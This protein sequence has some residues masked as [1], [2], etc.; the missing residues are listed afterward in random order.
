M[1]VDQFLP[2]E[3]KSL[4]TQR[5]ILDA[6]EEMLARYDFKYLTVRNICQTAGTASG[7]FYHHFGTKENVLIHCGKRLFHRNL[8][9]NPCP[10]EI[11]QGDYLHQ[12]MWYGIVLACFCETLGKEYVR[13]IY[14]SGENASDLFAELYD[15]YLFPVLDYAMANGYIQCHFKMPMDDEKVLKNLKKDI[16]IVTRGTVLYWCCS[17]DEELVEPF[18][19]TMEHML[20]RIVTGTRT[21][22][23]P[24]NY[25]GRTMLADAGYI[26]RLH[27]MDFAEYVRCKENGEE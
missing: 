16:L 24:A 26:D 20:Y 18:Y 5:K 22:K 3:L 8:R 19:A 15:R 23:R 7:S 17:K 21:E 9:N 6:S 14:L 11:D 13:T 27:M 1:A 10:P 12:A 25:I 4:E 2:R